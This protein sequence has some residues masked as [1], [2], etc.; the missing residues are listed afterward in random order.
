MIV[1]F[2]ELEESLAGGVI[3]AS[4]EVVRKLQQ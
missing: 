2:R 3:A 1:V 4:G